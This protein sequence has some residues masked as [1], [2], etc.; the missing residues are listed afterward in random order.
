MRRA[1]RGSIRAA[2][3]RVEL[4]ELGV[5]ARR[6]RR[7]RR[8]R[9][10]SAARSA[11]SSPGKREVVD[12]GLHVETGAADEQRAPA[13]RLDV[14]DRGARRGLDARDRPLLRTGRR[15][16]RGGAGPRRA[17]RPS[18]WRCRCR[19]RGTPASSRARRSRRRRAR[20]R[21]SSAERRLARR[22]R[23]DEREVRIDAA[24]DGDQPATTGMR[25]RA[26]GAGA[27]TSTSSPRSQCGAAPVTRD[28]RR[29]S[30]GARRLAGVGAAKCTSLFWRVR[31]DQHVGSFFDGPSTS[32][33]ST[34]PTRASCLRQ[35]VALDDLGE[36]RHALLHDLGGDEVVDHRRGL[37]ARPG[38]EHER[39]RRVVA[40]PRRRPRASRSKSASVSPG[41]PTMMSVVTAR[42]GIAARAAA[43]PLEVARGGV[44]AVHARERAVAPR[45]QRQVQVLAHAVALGHRRDR[46]GPEVLRVRRREA[47]ALDAVDRV[48][49]AQQVGELR[50]ALPG[51]EVAAVRV[52]VL[53]EQRDLDHAVGGELL[54]L[55]H[56]VAHA[57]ADLA[58]AHRGHDAERA[59][60]VAADLDRDPRRVVDARAG[61]A[62]P[63]GTPRA[64]RGS[65]RSAP[66]ARGPRAAA[67]AA[68]REVVGAEHDVDVRRPA[69]RSGRGPSGPGS[70]RP[71]SADRAGAPS[72]P[73]GGR[74]GRRACCRRS[75]GCSRC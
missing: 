58:A 48:E 23:A 16:R 1:L 20:A 73:S 2:A 25:T 44:A 24:C 70:R 49:R 51:A 7:A 65:R 22:G 9:A 37:G 45:L 5:G 61:P 59:R 55:V 31:P 71:R 10:S 11:R 8:S 74:G 4:R 38:R 41:K 18:A 26:R 30:P 72:A 56:D 15:R 12:D 75:P 21:R 67:S 46:L 43:E 57:A 68:R 13:A 3:D 29:A 53:A 42:S 36:P 63:T 47:D 6:G 33:S 52:D 28:R 17:R 32:T 34:R 69:P 40:R 54:D 35:R 62:A 39:V 64:P 60:V 19:G 14:G 27:D 66:S 50:A